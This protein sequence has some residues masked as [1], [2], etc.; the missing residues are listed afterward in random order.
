MTS[1]LSRHGRGGAVLELDSKLYYQRTRYLS[2]GAAIEIS[3]AAEVGVVFIAGASVLLP[4]S[5][6]VSLTRARHISGQGVLSPFVLLDPS[7]I[8]R[9][10]ANAPLTFD[11]T[12]L[13]PSHQR[14]DGVK[15]IGGYGTLRLQAVAADA[16]MRRQVVRLGETTLAFTAAGAGRCQQTALAG[17]AIASDN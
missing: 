11:G 4:M 17:K 1:A 3:A 10:V 6:D 7:A 14:A 13:E 5:C 9:G 8:R 12:T 15:F 16:G 2:G